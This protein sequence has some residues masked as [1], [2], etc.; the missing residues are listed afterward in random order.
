MCRRKS[1]PPPEDTTPFNQ[2]DIDEALAAE[3]KR[4][5]DEASEAVKNQDAE[6]NL[7]EVIDDE[8]TKAVDGKTLDEELEKMGGSQQTITNIQ[9]QVFQEVKGA[10]EK[11]RQEIR[12]RKE[13][14]LQRAIRQRRKSGFQ[15]RRSLI[16]GQSGGRGYA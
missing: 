5:A 2:A 12:K 4:L 10:S 6:T 9:N 7:L 11:E 14:Q 1:S 8:E 16:T 3:R 13:Q 15:G